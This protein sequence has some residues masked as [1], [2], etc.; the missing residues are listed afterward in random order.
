MAINGPVSHTSPFD[1]VRRKPAR[2]A[3][4]KLKCA[5]I[6]APLYER[7]QSFRVRT[8]RTAIGVITLALDRGLIEI[9]G[10]E[11][12]KRARSGKEEV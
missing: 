2:K 5:W 6:P 1:I 3:A 4:P 10:E 9:E 7:V 11:S 12:G 8:G